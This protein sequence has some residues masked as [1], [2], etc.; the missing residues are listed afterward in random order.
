MLEQIL[1]NLTMIGFAC[2]MLILAILA[3]SAFGLWYNIDTLGGS[4]D[5]S[6]LIKTG[7]KIIVFAIGLGSLTL[8]ITLLP[9]F[10]TYTGVEIEQI[11]I[12]TIS[13]LAVCGLFGA[14]IV[15]YLIQSV[16][17]LAKILKG[18]EILTSDKTES[19]G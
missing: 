8:A 19:E 11:V 4:F 18:N 12:D 15:Y 5:K 9:V 17:K 16:N 13:I 6:K 7:K 2:S 1:L 3:N 10:I 14:T